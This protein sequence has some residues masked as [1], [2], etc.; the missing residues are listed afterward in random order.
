MT[1]PM[2]KAFFGRPAAGKL[3]VDDVFSAYTYAG[4]SSAQSINNGIDLSAN[5]GLIWIKGLDIANAHMLYDTVRGGSNYLSSNS[6]AGQSLRNPSITSWNTSGFTVAGNDGNISYPGYKYGALTFRKAPKFFD[7]VTWTGDGTS[8]RAI[9]HNLGVTPGFIIVKRLDA[10]SNWVCYHRGMPTPANR[11]FLQGNNGAEL[12]NYWDIGVID[13]SKFH[14]WNGADANSSGASYVAYVFAHDSSVD[15]LIQ[16]GSYTGNGSATGPQINL[17]WEPQ[18]V[19]VKRADAVGDWRMIDSIRGNSLSSQALLRA[20][21]SGAE[22]TSTEG[23]LAFN[24]SGFQPIYGSDSDLNSSGSTYIY[25]AIRRSNKPPTIGVQVYNAKQHSN[26]GAS[27]V[28]VTGVGFAPDLSITTNRNAGYGS[29]F[30]DRVRGNDKVLLPNST[31][32]ETTGQSG[33]TLI[34]F[35]MDGAT[36]GTSG[37]VNGASYEQYIHHFFRRAPG[38]FDEVCYTGDGVN[39]RQLPHG[40]SVVPELV[41]HKARNTNTIWYVWIS[42]QTPSN[43]SLVL[44]NTNRWADGY[45][46]GLQSSSAKNL[47]FSTASGEINQTT[48]TYVAYLF[49]TLPGI[50]KV[51]SYTGNGTSQTINCGFAT[52]ARFILIKRT[53]AAGDWYVWDSVR[54]IVAANDPH[55][56]LNTVVMDVTTDDSVDPDASGFIVNQVAATNINVSGAS[57]IFLAIA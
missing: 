11:I 18:F 15:G 33:T 26:A 37:W 34:D 27:P 32:A 39:N 25:V 52:G 29:L 35:L 23:R 38:F 24:A 45:Q 13:S 17:G 54:G 50:S 6:T 16:C 19:L 42:G 57:Y 21:T 4:S 31:N 43:L 10:A 56:S 55:L 41:I 2:R 44:N 1:R 20:N 9:T 3:Y 28:S 53:D 48:Q 36:Y 30:N 5:H 51:G 8:A 46:T 7:V 12:G 49:A 22:V 47:N 40:L 14:V